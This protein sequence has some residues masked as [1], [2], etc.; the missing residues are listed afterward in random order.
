MLRTWA[1]EVERGS[2]GNRKV[3]SSIPLAPPSSSVEVSSEQNTSPLTAPDELAVA[4]SA[5]G[6]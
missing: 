6:V 2:A 4:D 3:A 5:L 1:Q